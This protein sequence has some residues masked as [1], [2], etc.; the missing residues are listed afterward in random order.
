MH[1]DKVRNIAIIAH[2]NHGKTRLVDQLLRQSGSF[3]DNEVFTERLMDHSDIE[4]KRGITISSKNGA[5]LYADHTI[6]I[7]DTPGQADFGGALIC[8]PSRNPHAVDVY[9]HGGVYCIYQ[10]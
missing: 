9:E 8:G 10:R 5:F 6:N 1:T 4:P 2:V 3:R 7:I